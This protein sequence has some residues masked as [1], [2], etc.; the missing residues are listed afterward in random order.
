MDGE[1]L[2]GTLVKET[3]RTMVDGTLNT[4][5]SKDLQLPATS[6]EV[7]TPELGLTSAVTLALSALLASAASYNTLVGSMP[8]NSYST[9]L[10]A[11]ENATSAYNAWSNP[12]EEYSPF[13]FSTFDAE[14]PP[15]KHTITV[16]V[17]EKLANEL[18]EG[19]NRVKIMRNSMKLPKAITCIRNFEDLYSAPSLQSLV[20]V[21]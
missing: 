17:H 2:Y 20:K 1:K 12:C 10:I 7:P 4:T 14:R 21:F 8:G 11:Y 13:S 19:S 6:A 15:K 16:L 9:A 18:P 5:A 3:L